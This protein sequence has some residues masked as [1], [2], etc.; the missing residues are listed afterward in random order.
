MS[1]LGFHT[2]VCRAAMEFDH[3]VRHALP[4]AD[5][6]AVGARTLE[7]ER[8]IVFSRKRADVMA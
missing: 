1:L 4:C 3:K 8:R 7:H 5:D 2:G 6:V